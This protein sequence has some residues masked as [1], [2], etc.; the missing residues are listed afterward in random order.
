MTYIPGRWQLDDLMVRP[1]TPEYQAYIAAVDARLAA[2]E[3]WREKLSPDLLAADFAA[4]LKE[5]D[6]LYADIA[7]L[8][9]YS[10]LWFSEDTANQDALGFRAAMQQRA[11]DAE[12]RGLF[13]TLWWKQLEDEPAAR[14]LEAS[15]DMRYHLEQL[16]SFKPHTL[17]E[18][19]ERIINL[20]NVNG[21]EAQLT[22]Y[23]IITT[24]IEYRLTIEGEEKT[25]TS[26]HLTAYVYQPDAAI[27]AAA[28]QE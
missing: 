5:Y 14:L 10:H 23:D 11:A 4:L 13:F 19:E 18:P 12:N 26:G 2:F 22:L 17:S 24:K 15:G 27:L 7:R 3:L 1:N 28:Y 6:A 25:I 20:K 21:I 16:R 9:A 8:I